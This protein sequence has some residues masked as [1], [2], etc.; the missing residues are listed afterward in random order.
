MSFID[1]IREC[2][3]FTPDG[4]RPFRIGGAV[5]GFVRPAFAG[6]L[7]ESPDV[8]QV[9]ADGVALAPGLK[10]A[11]ARSRAVAEV[12]LGLREKGA[13]IGWRDEPYP[14]FA[15]DTGEVLMTIERAAVPRFGAVASG[16]HLNGYVRTPD[17]LQMWL[18]RRSLH[19]HLAPGK[20]DQIV[21]GGRGSGLSVFDTLIKEAEEEASM[22]AALV[23]TARPV[24]CI[25]YCTEQDEGLR[26]DILYLFDL[27]LR[28]DFVPKEND[29]EI[30]EFVRWPIDKVM[31]AVRDTQDF[32]FNCSVVV[33]DFL[34]RH[35]LI[36]PE[37]PHYGEIAEGLHSGALAT[38]VLLGAGHG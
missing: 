25:T 24:G 38:A 32:K 10:T 3:R 26:R 15:P 35:G 18:G 37:E 31:A 27:E 34:M 20:L 7:A 2:A 22:P 1:R 6:L 23:R 4:Y 14:V 11:D 30:A 5:V 19:K 21:A 9:T 29:D 13:F 36:G 17:G 16:V 8:F 33:I 12:L 28:D